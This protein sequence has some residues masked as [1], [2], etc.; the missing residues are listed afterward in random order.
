MHAFHREC[1]YRN[2]KNY[3]TKDVRVQSMLKKLKRLFSQIESIKWQYVL[4]QAPNL[5]GGNQIAA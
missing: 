4:N 3:N 5:M 1:I 2:L